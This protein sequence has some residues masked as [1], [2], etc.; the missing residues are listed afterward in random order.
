MPRV[1]QSPTDHPRIRGEHIGAAA[2]QVKIT[3]SS[4]HTR[5]ARRRR[6]VQDEHRG[7]IP[8]YAGSTCN[9]LSLGCC[10]RDHPRIRGEH[11]R[12]PTAWGSPVGS[13]PHTR[14]APDG[15]SEACS[16]VRIIPAY[17]GSTRGARDRGG[18]LLGSSPHTRGAPMTSMC[19]VGIHG[20]IPAYAGS[21]STAQPTVPASKDHPRIRGEHGDGELAAL[22]EIG[23][24]PHTR[25][26]RRIRMSGVGRCRIIPAYAGSTGRGGRRAGTSRDHPRIRGEHAPGY[27][28]IERASGS[29]PHTRGAQWSAGR[30]SRACRIIPA[31]AGSTASGT[32]PR[33]T[34][35]DHPRIRGEHGE[36]AEH[37]GGVGGSSP[38]TRGAPSSQGRQSKNGRIIPA[39]AG[40]TLSSVVA[41]SS[42]ADHPRIRGEHASRAF[43]RNML[44]GS[45]PHT[46]G[47]LRPAPRRVAP[48]GIIPAYAGST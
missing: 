29:S 18:P 3:G 24:S 32:T 31:Y 23:S 4:P 37:R 41:S 7:I 22:R 33:G 10:A 11:W 34:L 43:T 36:A 14:G 6:P 19:G 1:S 48:C 13:S 26:A 9:V 16:G 30:R 28:A 46:R 42:P 39:Y 27:Q 45:S 35:R 44:D 8:A 47:A 2:H 12:G 38:H 17:A 21:T 15:F 5:G 40:S 20:I 25:G